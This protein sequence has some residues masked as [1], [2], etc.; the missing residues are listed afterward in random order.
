M[1]L[2]DKF[3][4][5]EGKIGVSSPGVYYV[6]AQVGQGLLRIC[7][8][9]SGANAYTVYAQV[10]QWLLLYVYPQVGQRH[11]VI[12]FT[13]HKATH[14]VFDWKFHEFWPGWVISTMAVRCL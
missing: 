8:G 9:G 5:K 2:E 11:R 6:Y 14:I 12:N 7:S 4:L 1:R 3:P 10:G 13:E